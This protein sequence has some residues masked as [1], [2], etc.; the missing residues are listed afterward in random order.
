MQKK[1]IN[2]ISVIDYIEKNLFEKLN[3]E[4][5]SNAMHY[6]KYHLHHMFSETVGITI[7][8]YILRRKLT[9]A[10]K[11]LVFSD[12]TI[13]DI[14]LI[15]G[16]ESQQAF[17]LV[18]K[19]LYKKTPNQFREQQEFYPLQLKFTLT[20]NP[21]TTQKEWG[22]EIVF[23]TE[24][25]IPQWL[26]LVRLVIDGFPNLTE[27]AYRENLI[28][29]IQTRQA[30]I[31][32]DQHLAVGILAFQRKTG[33]IDFFGI[34]PQYKDKGIANA[35]LK[36]VTA[37]LPDKKEISIT[38]FRQGDKADTGYRNALE[39]LGFAEAELLTE[40]GYPTQKM[41]LQT[42]NLEHDL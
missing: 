7:H 27:T 33:S 8:D 6:S 13:I 39:E 31:L 42:G 4:T 24:Q 22:Q 10:A 41:I 40:F 38:T 19:E 2:V 29:Y 37:E 18:F 36:K 14:A 17:T 21:T 20:E 12:K 32:K 11:L 30:L 28:W 25:D 3:L 9:E 1:I 35:F 23:A 5:V 16:Y 26:N 15:S 34:H